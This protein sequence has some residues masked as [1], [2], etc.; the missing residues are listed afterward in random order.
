MPARSTSSTG[1]SVW[2]KWPGDNVAARVHDRTNGNAF[3]TRG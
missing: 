1:S 3:V 2:T